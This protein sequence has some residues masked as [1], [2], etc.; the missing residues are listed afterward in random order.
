LLFWGRL[1]EAHQTVIEGIELARKNENAPWLGILLS[2]LAWLRWEAYDFDGVRALS[3]DVEQTGAVAPGLHVQLRAPTNVARKMVLI[4]QGF[5]DLATGH[6]DRALQCFERVREDATQTKS[7]LSWHRQLFARLGM[8]ETR[9]ALGDLPQASAE[10]D[11]LLQEVSICGDQYLKGRMWDMRAR[12]AM[13]SGETDRAEQSLLR[14]LEVVTATEVPLAAWR[15]HATASD[16]YRQTHGCRADTHRRRAKSIVLQLARSLENVESLR[17][18]FLGA[19][20]VRRI[21]DGIPESGRTPATNVGEPVASQIQIEPAP[22][23]TASL[24]GIVESALPDA[25][26]RPRTRLK[27]RQGCAAHAGISGEVAEA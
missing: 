4:L 26:P 9:L 11:A 25:L 18:S 27:R 10:A 16:F 13:T 6:F 24:D 19:L 21:L 15:I 8:A 7:G 22:R 23:P 1:G 2:T 17:L 14:G 3:I 20:P 12:L 5:T